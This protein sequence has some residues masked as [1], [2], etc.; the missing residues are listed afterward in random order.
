VLEEVKIASEASYGV[1]GGTM[2][3]LRQINFVFGT[4]GSGKTTISRVMNDIG[5]HPTCR[6]TWRGGRA[7]ECLVFNSDFARKSYAP[8]MAGIFTL[9][10]Q[11]NDAL[12][13]IASQKAIVSD[14]QRNVTQLETTLGPTDGRRLRKVR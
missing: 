14:L 8:Q 11:Q 7:I 5:A 6:T 4:N 3:E 9:G 10:E 13:R 2:S 12:Q 1:D